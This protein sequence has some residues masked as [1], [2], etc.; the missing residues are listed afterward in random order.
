MACTPPFVLAATAL[1]HPV[2]HDLAIARAERAILSAEDKPA[3]R[4]HGPRH[5]WVLSEHPE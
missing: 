1:A 4:V 2:D 3:E 5:R